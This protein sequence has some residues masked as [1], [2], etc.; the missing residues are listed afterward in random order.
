ML[1]ASP[2]VASRD[3]CASEVAL[4]AHSTPIGS[5]QAATKR[6]LS[7]SLAQQLRDK[8]RTIVFTQTVPDM[9]QL[10]R[11]TILTACLW[12]SMSVYA[13]GSNIGS[14][15]AGNLSIG[16]PW[17]LPADDF[18]SSTKSPDS[19]ASFNI[20][21]YNISANTPSPQSSSGWR[22][23]AAVKNDVSLSTSTNS[24]VNKSSVFEATTLYIQAPTGMEMDS[25]WRMCAVVYPGVDNLNVGNTVVDGGCSGV[26]SSGCLQA[27]SV[28]GTSGTNG[29]DDAGN[30]GSFVL[31]G[32]CEG[33]LSTANVTAFGMY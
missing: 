24:S 30:C 22:L 10:R 17:S 29:M 32:R 2:S 13:Y 28:A 14:F 19:V 23:S 33:S 31:P 18:E 16:A 7:F 3:S 20:T 27:L 11:A 15:V 1:V 9:N 21:G 4:L 12:Q 6:L 26:F 25:S 5:Y 8:T